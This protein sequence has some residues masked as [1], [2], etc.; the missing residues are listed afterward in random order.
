MTTRRDFLSQAVAVPAGLIIGASTLADS[1]VAAIPPAPLPVHE[2][3]VDGGF[4]A[5]RYVADAAE[6][7]RLPVNVIHGDITSLYRDLAPRWRESALTIAGLTGA[8]TLFVLERL[9]WDVGLRVVYRAEHWRID[10]HLM[11]HEVTGPAAMLSRA[12]TLSRTPGQWGSVAAAVLL[13]GQHAAR[14]SAPEVRRGFLST[15]SPATDLAGISW[16]IAPLQ[17]R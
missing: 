8:G 16:I 1:G 9:A 2:V 4:A 17:R 10:E 11:R 3:I 7:Q 12:R 5:G 6:S 13:S 15:A 14:R